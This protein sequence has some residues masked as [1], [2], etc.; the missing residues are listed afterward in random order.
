MIASALDT[1]DGIAQERSPAL[2]AWLRAQMLAD[3]VRVN[4]FE[5]MR[6]GAI[7]DNWRL[8]VAVEGG[9]WHGEHAFVLRTDAPSRVSA[10][11][12]RA[13]EFAVLRVAHDAGVLAPAPRFLGEDPNILGR[14][15]F[16]MDRLPGVAAGHRLTRDSA[17]VPNPPALAYALGANLARIHAI[18]PPLA[19]IAESPHDPALETIATYR[20]WLDALDD[21]YPALE[22]GLRWCERHAPAAFEVTLIHRDYRTGNYLVDEG[23]LTGVLDWEFAGFGDPREDLGWFTARC[24]RF[25]APQYEAGGI[26]PLTP[27]LDGYAS[28][29]KRRF[30]SEELVYWQVMAHLRWA[31]I[32]LQQARRHRSERSLELAL[33]GWIV[34]EL[35]CE[36]LRLIERRSASA[37]GPPRG[38]NSAPAGG[39]EAAKQRAWGEHA[40]DV[41]N[42]S[43]LLTIA[44][45]ALL[46]SLLPALA[47]EDRYTAL[48][49]ANAVAIAARESALGD[50]ATK[51]EVERLRSLT[52]D[53]VP[54]D[55]PDANDVAALRRRVT[56]A[57]RDGR[58]DDDAHARA[59]LCA[60]LDICADRVAISNPKALRE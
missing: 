25:A 50:A 47:G 11:L 26:A 52:T 51:R 16:I 18:R 19:P 15:F 32:A 23:R 53:I 22:F 60:L 27:F 1:V 38:A 20:R 34:D 46:S 28:V 58:F 54:P 3:D 4:C 29:A 5:R 42:A 45:D 9:S 33:T 31:I 57:I 30:S 6:G 37:D 41:A 10:S 12:T 2:A 48:M 21:T 59:L 35:A 7:Q 56:A 55:D 24:W 36:A 39:S 13:Q 17:L 49:V 44:R 14:A 43:D 8:D 40:S